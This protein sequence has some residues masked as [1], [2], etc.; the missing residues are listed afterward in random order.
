MDDAARAYIDTIPAAQRPLFDRL[1]GVVVGEFPDVEVLFAYK[2]PTYAVGDRRL[3]VAVWKHGLYGWDAER[4]G[5]FVA[6]HPEW[7]SGRGTLR[8]PTGAEVGRDELRDLIRGALEPQYR[9]QSPVMRRGRR[10]QDAQSTT[11][12]TQ[13]A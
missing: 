10:R 11:L 2:M 7:S 12:S 1:H 8:V 13:R 3:H 4:D 6:R 9:R 5:G